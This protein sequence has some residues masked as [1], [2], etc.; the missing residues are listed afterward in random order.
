LPTAFVF[1]KQGRLRTLNARQGYES[2]IRTLL[3]ER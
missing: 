1:D 2:L 3:A